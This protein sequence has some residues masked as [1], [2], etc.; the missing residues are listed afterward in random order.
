MFNLQ[1][2]ADKA[3]ISAGLLH[4]WVSTGKVKPSLIMVADA[5]ACDSLTQRALK[6]TNWTDKNEP[7]NWLFSEH[8]V[9]RLQKMVENSAKADLSPPK[10]LTTWNPKEDSHKRYTIK[11]LASAWGF[12]DDTIRRLFENEKDVVTIGDKNP[13]G[14]RRR[15]TIRIPHFV[16]ARV[17]KKLSIV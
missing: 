15:V 12:S 10:K 1:Q 5:N 2:A 7:S 9:E 16:A 8:D 6:Q 14:K 17:H 4:L 13:R 3:G 11:E